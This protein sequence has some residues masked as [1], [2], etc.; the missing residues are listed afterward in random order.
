MSNTRPIIL[1]DLDDTLF[2][3]YR[4][5]TP[6]ADFKAVTVDKHGE[7]LAYMNPKQQ[8]FV[9]WLWSSGKV[10]AVTARSPEA[11]S[12]VH[13]PFE[14]GAVCSHGGTVLNADGTVNA[15]YQQ[16]M[17]QQLDRY[18]DK[19]EQLMQAVLDTAK[20]FGSVRSWIVEEQNLQLYLVVKQ[21]DTDGH[22]GLFLMDLL[23]ALPQEVLDGFYCHANG[24]NL[25]IIPNP[26]SKANAAAFLLKQVLKVDEQDL[27]LGYGDSLSD[28]AFLQMCDW[29]GVPQL[30]QINRFVSHHVSDEYQK[31]G[32]FGDYRE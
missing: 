17:V 32:Y 21:N 4:R 30:S 5:I 7:T 6:T 22:T 2:Q 26:V 28:V 18:K 24:N 9:D 3:T 8:K 12:R 19:F 14:H 27:I 29:W 23:H 11:L 31:Q 16:L 1:V 15:D 20:C 25:A 13:L 10:L